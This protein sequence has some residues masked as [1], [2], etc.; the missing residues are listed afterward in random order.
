MSEEGSYNKTGWERYHFPDPK[1]DILVPLYVKL[2]LIFRSDAHGDPIKQL[3]RMLDRVRPWDGDGKPIPVHHMK[4]RCHTKGGTVALLPESV[5][6]IH[7][8]TYPCGGD[9][10]SEIDR[11][12]STPGVVTFSSL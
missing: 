11:N 9:F 3:Q 2:D 4:H 10:K 12:S 7:H 8:K 1:H 6:K 5:H